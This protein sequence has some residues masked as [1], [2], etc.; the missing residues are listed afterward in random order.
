MMNLNLNKNEILDGTKNN[1]R[2][3]GTSFETLAA[4]YL[5]KQ[6]LILIQRNFRCRMGE[7]DLIFREP[8]REPIPRT[9][10]QIPPNI[11]QTKQDQIVFVEVRFRK[12]DF[13]GGGIQSVDAKKQ[14]K[15]IQSAQMFLR[16]KP[17]IAHFPC[18]FDVVGVTLENK[19][20]VFEWIQNAFD[21]H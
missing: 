14:K 1:T 12:S 4:D 8:I 11:L 15:L 17:T 7:I 10:E 2:S 18:R 3:C 9:A 20:P 13:F 19:R 5:T 21:A 16:L 6:G